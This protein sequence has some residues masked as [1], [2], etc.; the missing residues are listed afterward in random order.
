MATAALDTLEES[1][2]V[3]MLAAAATL[4]YAGP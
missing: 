3:F 2:P 1:T 4:G